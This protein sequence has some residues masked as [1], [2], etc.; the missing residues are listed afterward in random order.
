MSDTPTA[1]TPQ[2]TSPSQ[3]R[4]GLF[5][6]LEMGWTE[7]PFPFSSFK[8]K[9]PEQ[10]ATI[11]AM[12]LRHVRYSPE[13]S[14]A[15]PLAPPPFDPAAEEAPPEAPA[16]DA[17]VQRS[18]HQRIERL[19][20]HRARVEA[21]EKELLTK[22]RI[23]KSLTQNL[24]SQ[25]AQVRK[26]ATD[27]VDEMARSLLVDADIAIHLMADKVGKE[28]VYLH[29]LN[30]AMLSMML[31][32]ELKA[33]PEALRAIGLGALFHDVGKIDMPDRIVRK[34]EPWNKAELG[35]LQ[36]HCARGLELARKLE[37]PAEALPGLTQHHELLDGT[38][39][40]KGLKGE[41]ISLVARIVALV[42][43]YDNLCNPN[44]PAKALTPHEALST[45]FGQ[46]RAQ[47][48]ARALT[49]FVRCMGIYPPGTI[50]VLNNGAIGMVTAVNSTRPL[51][52]SVLIHDPSLKREE[53]IIIDLEQE[54]DASIARTLRPQQLSNEVHAYLSPSRRITHYFDA[55]PKT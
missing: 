43:R 41:Q 36:Q 44:D 52:P 45:I 49:T 31:A 29:S 42:N 8:I 46:Q 32:K 17:Q 35:L 28:E 39:Y 34:T 11:Q 33:P 30:V 5:I 4:I 55:E 53:A 1:D 51:K 13:R 19:V 12:G 26:D 54:P 7:H 10:V 48:D 23:V 6:H 2:Y 9:S 24:F 21:C 40:P 37:L 15:E 20:A 27:L 18:K 22:S 14:D 25:P 47:F 50:V 3:L 38:G 16:L